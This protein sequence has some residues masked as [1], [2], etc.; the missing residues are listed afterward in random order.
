M[1]PSG[2]TGTFGT[3]GVGD[4]L[5]SVFSSAGEGVDVADESTGTEATTDVS[6]ET[7]DGTDGA[8]GTEEA[9]EPQEGDAES[10]EEETAEGEVAAPALK[11]VKDQPKDLPAGVTLVADKTGQYYQVPL[12]SGKQFFA[13]ATQMER[14]REIFGEDITPELLEARQRDADVIEDMTI[15]FRSCD[16]AQT[17]ELVNLFFKH[18]DASMKNGWTGGD[19]MESFTVSLLNGLNDLRPDIMQSME[20][21]LLESIV[22]TEL[23]KAHTAGDSELVNA[24]QFFQK[25]VFGKFT[26]RAEIKPFS[27]RKQ[28]RG[29]PPVRSE[30]GAATLRRDNGSGRDAAQNLEFTSTKANSDS[31]TASVKKALEP[32]TEKFKAD[33]KLLSDAEVLCKEAVIRGMRKDTVWTSRNLAL[34]RKARVATSARFQQQITQEIAR[35]YEAKANEILAREKPSILSTATK[36]LVAASTDKHNKL[37]TAQKQGGIKP[38]SGP[39]LK[40]K[41]PT[42]SNGRTATENYEASLDKLFANLG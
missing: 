36:Q 23:S 26:K 16:R 40:P 12:E 42:K 5:D 35:R 38:G 7:A 21:N 15:Q 25:G 39:P 4:G 14:A 31:V 8:E 30:D 2:D 41:I 37:A 18:A 22:E 33:P 32:F 24:I 19:P 11:P 27:E 13:A 20:D 28:Y 1:A 9:S 29:Q 3:S 10:A 6:E 34:F 17:D